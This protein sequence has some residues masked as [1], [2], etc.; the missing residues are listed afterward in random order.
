MKKFNSITVNG[1]YLR[2]E[3]ARY[4]IDTNLVS[5][6]YQKGIKMANITKRIVRIGKGLSQEKQKS[7]IH[8]FTLRLNSDIIALV[9]E[10]VSKHPVI[11][12]RTTWIA[13][14][15]VEQLKREGLA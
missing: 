9:D 12:N 10:A 11:R 4:I 15:V 7:E 8:S 1:K 13:N 3:P 6:L 5:T 14:A 2:L